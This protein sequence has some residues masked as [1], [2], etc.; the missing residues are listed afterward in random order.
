M[1]NIELSVFKTVVHWIA[2]G[3][4]INVAQSWSKLGAVLLFSL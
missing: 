3:T 4:L 2:G 1:V